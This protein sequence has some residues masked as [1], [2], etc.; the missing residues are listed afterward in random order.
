M[1]LHP[2]T[3]TRIA[4]CTIGLCLCGAAYYF[5]VAPLRAEAQSV[6]TEVAALTAAP[7]VN[8]D[9]PLDP[10][11]LRRLAS[12]L[13]EHLARL[14]TRGAPARDQTELF[15][16]VNAL[17]ER[18]NLRIDRLAAVS[19]RTAPTPPAPT[20]PTDASG[21]PVLP[22]KDIRTVYSI[23]VQ[24]RYEDLPPLLTALRDEVGLCVIRSLRL[25]A[26]GEVGQVILPVTLEVEAFAIDATPLSS[27]LTPTAL[28]GPPP[29]AEAKP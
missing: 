20:P 29:I 28:P 14:E 11:R 12:E 6:R 24:A 10:E 1:N 17:A 8:N 2:E 27:L 26:P 25:T 13:R 9:T 22:R 7:R 15:T 21:Q 3:R 18:L 5:L 23:D 16:R 19:Q 4:E